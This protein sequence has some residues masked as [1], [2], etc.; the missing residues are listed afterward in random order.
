MNIACFILCIV[1]ITLGFVLVLATLVFVVIVL[2]TLVFMTSTFATRSLFAEALLVMGILSFGIIAVP[3]FVRW[4]LAG[5]LGFPDGGR[6]RRALVVW[7]VRSFVGLG[8]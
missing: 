4:G 8:G 6:C 2:S 3:F 7:L 1:T 5:S